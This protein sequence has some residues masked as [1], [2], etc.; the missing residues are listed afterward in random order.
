MKNLINLNK[1]L[2]GLT[3]VGCLT[4]IAAPS[5]Q[6]QPA[7]GSYVGVGASFGFTSGNSSAGE[8]SRT[9]G[10]IAARYKFLEFPVSVRTQILIGSST[11]V[12]P[13]VSFDVPLNFDTDVYI[14]AGVALSNTVDTTP[15]GN[16]NSFVIQPGID[17]TVPNSNLV[18]FGNVI[19]AFD[20]YRNSPGTSATSLQTGLG[21]RF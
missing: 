5:A 7:Y 21:L 9:S 18:L 1:I 10:L 12:V 15:V 6:A 19:F 11:A 3:A 17:Y 8:S 13:T 2:L 4:A 14:G 20:A 16:R